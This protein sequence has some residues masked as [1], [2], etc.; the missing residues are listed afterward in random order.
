[1]VGELSD[2]V[3]RLQ[4]MLPRRWFSDFAPNLSALLAGLAT[5]FVWLNTLVAYVATQSRLATA[6]D[7]WLDMAA[8]DFLGEHLVRRSGEPDP[9]YRLRIQQALFQESATRPALIAA[10]SLLTGTAPRVFEP[11]RCGDTGAYG[12]VT[13][14][15][16]MTPPF[17]YNQAGGW[18]NLHM[19]YQFFVSVIRPATPGVANLCG[20]G[21]ASGGYDAGNI[22]YVDLL[23]L[24]GAVSDAEIQAQVCRVL[25]VNATA[26]LRII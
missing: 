4:A 10:M 23:M 7:T 18:G 14:L 12:S 13:E 25:P 1:M 6:T 17:S 19:P 20:Y 22:S 15:P 11:A 2:I 9:S 8:M 26:W 16:T 24:P 5:P 3:N 21:C